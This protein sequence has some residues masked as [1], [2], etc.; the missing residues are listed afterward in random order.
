MPDR[1]KDLSKARIL[2]SNDD[3]IR[4]KGLGVLERVAARLSD[5]VWVVAPD[6]EQSGAAHSLTLSRPLRLR[7]VDERRYSVDGTPTDSVL[8]GIRQVLGDH[9]PDLVLSGVNR[10]GN[11]GED[12]TYSGTVAAAMEGTLLGVPSV[13]LSQLVG[14][15]TKAHWETAERHA[16][17]LLRR[18]IAAPWPKNVLININFPDLPPD[19]VKGTAIVGL[20]RR[21]IGGQLVERR[22]PRGYPYYW[23]G[24][25]REEQTGQP[26]SDIAAVYDGWISITPVHLDLTDKRAMAA[27]QKAFAA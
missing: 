11:L 16:P 14:A 9:K 7:R 18:L 15:G 17:D 20:G 24:P 25:M 2:I 22:D 26:G 12:V 6:S 21:K 19:E 27:L 10:G 23:I 3:G 13:A 4:A 1:L 5:D 8:M